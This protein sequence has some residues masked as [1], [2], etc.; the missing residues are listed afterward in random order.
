MRVTKIPIACS[1]TPDAVVDRME[2]W[3]FLL[4]T[5]VIRVERAPNQATLTLGD[6]DALLMA[7]DLAEREKACCPFF[8]FSIEL[9]GLERRLLIGVPTEAEEIL[10]ELLAVTQPN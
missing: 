3:R 8:E 5:M 2:E 4:S 9:E 1:L 10:T 6:G 7:T